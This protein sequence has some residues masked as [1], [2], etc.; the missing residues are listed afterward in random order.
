M[1]FTRSLLLCI[2]CYVTHIDHYAG[3]EL[4]YKFPVKVRTSRRTRR[5]ERNERECVYSEELNSFYSEMEKEVSISL[6]QQ[7]AEQVSIRLSH[8]FSFNVQLGEN[9]SQ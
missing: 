5:G 1:L 2:V 7:G 6:H 8:W 3:F 4:N 9:K